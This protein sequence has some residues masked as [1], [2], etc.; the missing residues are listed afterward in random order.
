MDKEISNQFQPKQEIELLTCVSVMNDFCQL[1][2]DLRRGKTCFSDND[3][4]NKI[5]ILDNQ[6]NYNNY[7]N[8]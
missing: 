3:K 7:N 5:N 6:N 4:P 8:F 2:T 1:I